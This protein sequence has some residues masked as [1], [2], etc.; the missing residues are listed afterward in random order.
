M[1]LNEPK[2]E[3]V[4]YNEWLNPGDDGYNEDEEGKEN[5]ADWK[6]SLNDWLNRDFQE[7]DD[8]EVEKDEDYQTDYA[9]KHP[10]G[11]IFDESDV[12]WDYD[13]EYE[14]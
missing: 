4:E 13:L 1:E 14:K 11:E 12:K 6:N 7:D 2:N 3:D 8:F 5:D 10:I 9:N